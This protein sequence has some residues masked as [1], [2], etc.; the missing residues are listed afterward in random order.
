MWPTTSSKPGSSAMGGLVPSQ[1]GAALQLARVLD[2]GGNI[3]V[4]VDQKF[5]RGVKTHFFGRECRTN[6]LLPKLARQCDC[7]VYPGPLQAA[8]RRALPPDRRRTGSPC[9][10]RATAQST[11]MPAPS[12]SMTWSSAGCA[13]IPASGCGST[14]AGRSR[15]RPER[16]I[17]DHDPRV[18]G[19]DL[20]HQRIEPLR[21][22]C[23]QTHTAM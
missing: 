5:R 22:G 4:L 13:R 8:T 1:A 23:V 2:D 20:F 17:R 15:V 3:G 14:S 9:R 12:C 6:P 11:S 16:S 10:G 7:D 21:V 19:A 18:A